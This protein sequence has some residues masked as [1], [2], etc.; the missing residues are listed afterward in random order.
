VLRRLCGQRP[1]F[2]GITMVSA[3]VNHEDV[4]LAGVMV[5]EVMEGMPATEAG[6]KYGDVILGLN[7]ERWDPNE[8][9][10]EKQFLLKV[11]KM[12]PGTGI[13][14]EILRKKEIIRKELT[15]VARPWSAG[16]PGDQEFRPRYN[17]ELEERAREEVFKN[18]LESYQV[19]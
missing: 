3:V 6:L 18:W 19:P 9:D 12:K 14:L 11:S 1:G 4:M 7:G 10:T 13:E 17:L 8:G 15:L 5:K 2:V 16:E